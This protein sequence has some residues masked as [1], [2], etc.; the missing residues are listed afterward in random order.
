[1]SDADVERA[2]AAVL[3]ED[4]VVGMLLNQHARIR[5]LFAEVRTESGQ[6]KQHAFDEL[7]ALLAVHETAEEMI[8][9]P[10]TTQVDKSVADARDHEE[11]EAGH[12]LRALEKMDVNSAE[13][14][15]ELAEFEQAVSHHAEHEESEEFPRVR[16][17]RN[18][19]E[20]EKMG[21]RL[22]TAEK[23]APTHPH[24]STAGS[25]AAQWTVGPIVSIIDR[26]RDAVR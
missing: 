8:V 6:H 1:M 11:D 23:I 17:V 4:D 5:D 10:V 12:V 21:R 7:R 14:D 20:L 15:R 22:R 13:F 2:R 19:E 3:P 16:G 26:V 24:P 18:E 9:R 25:T